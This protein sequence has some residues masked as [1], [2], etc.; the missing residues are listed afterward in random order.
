MELLMSDILVEQDGIYDELKS[1]LLQK[2]L[3]L[4]L[5]KI[6]K[7]DKPLDYI[8]K[9]ELGKE[10]YWWILAYYNNIINPLNLSHLDNINIPEKTELDSLMVEIKQGLSI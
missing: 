4:P 2:V 5:Y 1:E 10:T 3:N 6:V 9:E 7:A 8:A